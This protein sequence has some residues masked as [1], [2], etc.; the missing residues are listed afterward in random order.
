MN[1]RRPP[2]AVV[3]PHS[4]PVII[5]RLHV[6]QAG[7]RSLELLTAA[8]LCALLETFIREALLLF[9]RIARR[10]LSRRSDLPAFLGDH[11]PELGVVPREPVKDFHCIRGLSGHWLDPLDRT[12]VIG[13]CRA[14]RR[15]QI[16]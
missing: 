10:A 16:S 14:P 1:A 5:I 15:L 2:P 12:L 4:E 8:A 3:F 6:W 9:L 11:L 13:D 7:E